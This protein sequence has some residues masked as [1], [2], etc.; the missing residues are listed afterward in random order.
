KKGL[1]FELPQSF[2]VDAHEK[3]TVKLGLNVVAGQLKKGIHQ[4]FLTLDGEGESYQL[5]YLFVN[6]SADY[7]KAM[8]FD[9]ELKPLSD[10]R[11]KYQMYVT[12]E[13]ERVEVQLF[14]YASLLYNRPILTIED[15][16]TGMN[17]GE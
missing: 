14:D 5:P 10:E 8:G 15:P 6:Q 9:L 2:S 1:Q 16:E 17:E 13:A 7:P 3:K 11:Y 4:G 12:D